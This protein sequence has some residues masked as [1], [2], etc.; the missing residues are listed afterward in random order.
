MYLGKQTG[1]TGT[2][3]KQIS[4]AE[5]ATYCRFLPEFTVLSF[6]G[7]VRAT[8]TDNFKVF[9]QMNINETDDWSDTVAYNTTPGTDTFVS[10][11]L[12]VHVEWLGDLAEYTL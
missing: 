11:D 1:G 4:M 5:D 12:K 9:T 10:T 8:S 2:Y 3:D 6:T 7:V